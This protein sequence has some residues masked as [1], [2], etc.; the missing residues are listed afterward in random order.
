MVAKSKD[1]FKAFF[2]KNYIDIKR[3]FW[4]STMPKNKSPI[5]LNDYPRDGLIFFFIILY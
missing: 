2:E 4:S 1:L 5:M 3:L